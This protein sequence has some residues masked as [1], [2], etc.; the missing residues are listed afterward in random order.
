MNSCRCNCGYLAVI[1]SILAGVAL[2][3][4]YA[5]GF[6]ATGVLF[7]P[8]ALIGAAALLLA[9]LYAAANCGCFA[10]SRSL[11]LIAAIGTLIAAAV[12]LIV[13]SVAG[14]VVIGIAVGV[15]TFFVTLLLGVIVCL[16]TCQCER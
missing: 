1:V 10:G 12:G 5:L 14:V 13:A 8:Y 7:W 2:G 11:F 16:T 15:A 9:P 6:I 3:V 4:L